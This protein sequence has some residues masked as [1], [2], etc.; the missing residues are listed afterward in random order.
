MP[1]YTHKQQVN[2]RR[3]KHAPNKWSRC[4]HMLSDGMHACPR[5]RHVCKHCTY[6]QRCRHDFLRLIHS[7]MLIY[8]CNIRTDTPGRRQTHIQM[9]ACVCVYPCMYIACDAL[10][11]GGRTTR[12]YIY[13]Y[14]LAQLRWYR[15]EQSDKEAGGWSPLTEMTA[16]TTSSMNLARIGWNTCVK[17]GSLKNCSQLCS[18]GHVLSTA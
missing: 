5:K 18:A 7:C 15:E 17:L 11:D 13:I 10:H 4:V 9:C 12:T 14:F 8:A 6:K 16:N 2:T 1:I 3:S